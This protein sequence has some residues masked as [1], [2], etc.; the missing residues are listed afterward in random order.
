MYQTTNL[1]FMYIH[2]PRKLQVRNEVHIW[3]RENNVKLY[4]GSAEFR[5]GVDDELMTIFKLK[6]GE[7]LCQ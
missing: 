5:V 3:A 7:Y 6:F 1:E 4:N 2:I